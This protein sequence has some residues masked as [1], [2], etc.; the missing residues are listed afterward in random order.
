MGYNIL[1][2]MP[3]LNNFRYEANG[4]RAPSG[5]KS[6][7]EER[8]IRSSGLNENKGI[9]REDSVYHLYMILRK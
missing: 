1:K 3:L 2:L 5:R 4:F 9:M 6:S 8:V 7:D